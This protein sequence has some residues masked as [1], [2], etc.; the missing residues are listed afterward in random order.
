MDLKRKEHFYGSGWSFPVQFTAGNYQVNT[1]EFETNV[2]E[3]IRI[4]LHTHR[5]ERLLN[6]KFG[7]GLQQFFF[8]SMDERL[9]SEI[10]EAVRYALLINEPRITVKEVNVFFTDTTNGKVDITIDYIFND[11]NTRHNYVFPFHLM[12]ATHLD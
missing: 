7:S 1:T 10:K 11:T 5:G 9:K 8:R 3:S 12:E 2:N 6:P 4:I